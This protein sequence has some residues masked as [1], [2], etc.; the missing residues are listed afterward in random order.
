M[1]QEATFY[2]LGSQDCVRLFRRP[3]Q[4]EKHSVS[5]RLMRVVSSAK[6]TLRD[7]IVVSSIRSYSLVQQHEERLRFV[8]K[9]FTLCLEPK[10]EGEAPNAGNGLPSFASVLQHYLFISV[11]HKIIVMHRA[12]LSRKVSQAERDL[13]HAACIETARAVLQE[14]ERGLGMN[15]DQEGSQVDLQSRAHGGALWTIPYHSVAAATIIALDM[16]RTRNA[17]GEAD[18][19]EEKR[20]ATRREEVKR[21]LHALSTFT[22]KSAIAR[23]GCQLL[24]DLLEEGKRWDEGFA[25]RGKRKA[26]DVV[27]SLMKRIRV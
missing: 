16:F 27:G 15:T 25:K 21:A 2:L 8:T 6:L 18:A 22:K 7:I 11:H 26:G 12:F 24:S 13:S 17:Q 10:K 9:R 23:R 5:G 1:T 20:L 3:Q 19:E 4:V 14:L